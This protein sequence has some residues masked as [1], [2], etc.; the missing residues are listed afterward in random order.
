[1]KKIMEFALDF[2]R[3]GTSLYL[4]LASR[5]ENYL[6]K[7]LFYTLAVQEI[8]H[9]RRIDEFYA[10][11]RGKESPDKYKSLE[12]V[13]KEMKTFFEH[14]RGERP[15][16]ESNLSVY[17]T[18]MELEREGYR[19]YEKFYEETREADEKQLLNFLLGEERKHI[20]AI[21]NIYSYLSGTGDWFEQ[22]ESRV[23]N[24]MNI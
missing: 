1:M 23:W 12:P 13:E 8:D 9:A 14:V 10:G 5:V 22:E 4:E 16:H 21:T 11:I 15:A 17:E 19:A 6:S 2:E 24:W 7:K 18:A 20:E 3:R